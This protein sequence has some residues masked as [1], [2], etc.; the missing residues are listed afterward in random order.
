MYAY[1]VLELPTSVEYVFV[2]T[3]N[4]LAELWETLCKPVLSSASFLALGYGHIV[5]QT[6]GSHLCTR[7][8]KP[9]HVTREKNVINFQKEMI[10]MSETDIDYLL[11]SRH[12]FC[13]PRL[14]SSGGYPGVGDKLPQK[15][16]EGKM[17]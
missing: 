11:Q 6:Q 14:R 3:R 16:L 17:I 15:R 4:V 9:G 10:M 5:T 13:L 12:T 1:D 2:D 7:G 8:A